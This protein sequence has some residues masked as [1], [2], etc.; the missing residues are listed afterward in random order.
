MGELNWY[1]DLWIALKRLPAWFGCLFRGHQL[2]KSEVMD[3]KD[4]ARDGAYCRNCHDVFLLFKDYEEPRECP[5]CNYMTSVPGRRN[6][7]KCGEAI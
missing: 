1:E 5:G 4:R 7:P 3:E 2:V 6:C